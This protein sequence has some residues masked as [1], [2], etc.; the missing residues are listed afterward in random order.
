MTRNHIA[1]LV[2]VLALGAVFVLPASGMADETS[3]GTQYGT[4]DVTGGGTAPTATTAAG[5]VRGVL[6]G[7]TLRFRGS[8]GAGAAGRPVTVERL[9]AATG[10]LSQ[11]SATAGSDGSFLASWTPRSPGTYTLRAVLSGDDGAH[12]SAAPVLRQVTVYRPARATWFG[13]GFY[14]RRTAC[15]QTMSHALLG[16]AHRSLP[17]GTPVAVL[18]HGRTVTVPV[19]DRGPFANGAR[20]DLTS[21]TAQALGFVKTDTVGVVQAGPA[22]AAA[23]PAAG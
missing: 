3:G 11:S 19:V 14:G 23:A 10:W 6:L 8:L 17:C 13:P 2:V 9:D 7:R 5:P 15:G 1:K 22:P 21:A 20:Y 12:A 4:A 18:Y 16:V